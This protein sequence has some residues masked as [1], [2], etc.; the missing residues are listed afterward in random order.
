MNIF[1]AMYL[2]I[3][4]SIRLYRWPNIYIGTKVNIYKNATLRGGTI[5]THVLQIGNSA[6]IRETAY[7]SASKSKISIGSWSYIA[8]GTWIGGKGN[9]YIG[10]NT[11]IGMNTIIIS[12]NHNY[13]RITG[14]FY[15]DEEI[16]KDISIGNNVWIGAGSIILPGVTVE[17][18]AVV[19]AGSVVTQ[20]VA[21]NTMVVGNPAI[22]K[23]E[24]D[25]ALRELPHKV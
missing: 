7:I 20:D 10:K 16:S 9:I 6:V 5:A 19:A 1:Q 3:F 4:K 17:D 14:N 21:S 12:S 18:N 8:H 25:N 24:F 23:K 13:M 2:S 15:R 22:I 11:L